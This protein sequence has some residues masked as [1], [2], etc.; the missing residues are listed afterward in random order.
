MELLLTE[1]PESLLHYTG[2]SIPKWM[3]MLHPQ[4]AVS[5][6]RLETDSGGLVYNDVWRSAEISLWAMRQ[7]S[8]VQPPGF[9]GH[10]FGLSI[11]FAVDATLKKL[12]WDY[13]TFVA[14]LEARNWF[15]HRRDGKRGSEDWHFNF[16]PHGLLATLID[17]KRAVTWA[18]PVEE[19][20]KALY[21]EQLRLGAMEQQAA[22]KGLKLYTGDID[23]QMG[24][25]TQRAEA[26]F[27]EKWGLPIAGENARYQRTLAFVTATK[28]MVPL[29]V[30]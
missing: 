3:R 7:K 28:K 29:P 10:G 21:G 15:C 25:K 5:V 12:S 1:L 19:R 13:A 16:L 18:A 23:G 11:D 22:L 27:R 8:G 14:F 30:G 17:V 24:P 26:A 9:S 20:I 4:A 6:L 2:K